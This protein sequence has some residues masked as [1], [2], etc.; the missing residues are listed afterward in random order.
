MPGRNSTKLVCFVLS[1][2]NPCFVRIMVSLHARFEAVH[3]QSLQRVVIYF[4][5]F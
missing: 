2:D 3:P 4:E 5:L 1:Y